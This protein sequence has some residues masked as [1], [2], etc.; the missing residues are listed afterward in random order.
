[1]TGEALQF[2]GVLGH[3]E[4]QAK[5]SSAL[6]DKR[7]HHAL[8]FVGAHGVGKATVARGLGAALHCRERPAI[9]CSTCSSCRRVHEGN[10]VGVEWIEPEG[11]GGL[12]KVERARELRDRLLHA[13]FEG[14][15]H[16]VV[17]DPADSLGEAAA[18]ALLKSLEEPAAGVYFVLI[19]DNFHDLLPTVRSRCLPVRFGPL[20]GPTI[21]AIL[22]SRP[23]MAEVDAATRELAI[24]VADGSAGLAAT[25]ALDPALDASFEVLR[26]AMHA[27]RIGSEAIF[28]GKNGPLWL[29]W[30]AATAGPATG[31]PARERAVARRVTELWMLH[32]RERL[33]GRA[34]LSGLPD[35]A[36]PLAELRVVHD[37]LH[38]LDRNPNVRLALEHAL[39]EIDT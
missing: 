2:P 22:E 37:L 29:S 7:L 12:I 5:L 38:A 20:P 15:A 27:A 16:L 28:A 34:G 8:A 1:M 36:R 24:R 10:H 11:P 35:S 17:I 32:V 23:D 19:T 30:E 18:N 4:V 13:P 14:D 3:A 33:R 9:G 25:L 39:L 26:Q 6:A 21:H 31:R